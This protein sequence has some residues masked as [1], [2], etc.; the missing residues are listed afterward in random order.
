MLDYREY[1]IK[2]NKLE[3]DNS[4]LVLML[5]KEIEHNVEAWNIDGK[6]TL[7]TVLNYLTNI[8]KFT[9]TYNRNP[10]NFSFK[11][12]D[13][14]KK[15][16]EVTLRHGDFLDNFPS[17]YIKETKDG[18]DVLRK[19]YC[20]VRNKYSSYIDIGLESIDFSKGGIT[21]GKFI[22]ENFSSLNVYCGDYSYKIYY[23]GLS[24]Q[25]GELELDNEV[26]L[27][28]RLMSAKYPMS[29][30]ELYKFIKESV[31]DLSNL[32]KLRIIVNDSKNKKIE[33]ELEIV[34]NNLTKC[35]T[36]KKLSG[37]IEI[38]FTYT[39]EDGLKMNVCNLNDE[40]NK[41]LEVMDEAETELETHKQ[42]IKQFSG[43]K[44][45]SN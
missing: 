27:M 29:S 36:T 4:P 33:G 43:Y 18:V 2:N 30:I 34:D 38:V 23:Y 6:K 12:K 24:G 40:K 15:D 21:V 5:G 39:S 10:K 42:F 28:N 41:I 7:I 20:D 35:L 13:G 9:K 44:K 31:K 45:E 17:V 22:G 26:E 1:R 25:K 19:Y 16:V 3:R 37:D 14:M 11:F 32:S 8:G